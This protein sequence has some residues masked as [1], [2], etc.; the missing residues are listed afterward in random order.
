MGFDGRSSSVTG[1]NEGAGRGGRTE[2]DGRVSARLTRLGVNDSSAL[3]YPPLELLELGNEGGIGRGRGARL[4]LALS[5]ESPLLEREDFV[6][7][8]GEGGT[9]RCR[10][11]VV[12]EDVELD[13]LNTPVEVVRIA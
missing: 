10:V 7:R 12:F 4:S 8:E 2:N 13:L 11:A 5:P 6:D 1:P 9:Y 3:K